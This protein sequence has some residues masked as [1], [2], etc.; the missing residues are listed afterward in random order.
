MSSRVKTI[1]QL[2]LVTFFNCLLI[3]LEGSSK[4]MGEV[5]SL[6]EKYYYLRLVIQLELTTGCFLLCFERPLASKYFSF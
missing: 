2:S 5:K 6:G 3:F 1:G 4:R